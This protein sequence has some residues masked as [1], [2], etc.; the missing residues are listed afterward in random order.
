MKTRIVAL[1]AVLLASAP[2]LA[3]DI[4]PFTGSFVPSDNPTGVLSNGGFT[5]VVADNAYGKPPGYLSQDGDNAYLLLSSNGPGD[6]PQLRTAVLTFTA[7]TGPYK[8]V[9]LSGYWMPAL[10]A[11][12]PGDSEYFFEGA[13]NAD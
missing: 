1:A 3:A 10:A 8:D 6:P 9:Q 13:P 11:T 5:E 12:L 4:I 7:N 2:A